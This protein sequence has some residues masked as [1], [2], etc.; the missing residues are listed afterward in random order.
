VLGRICRKDIVPEGSLSTI[1]SLKI[2][3]LDHEHRITFKIIVRKY[4]KVGVNR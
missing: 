2:S 3:P 1:L 4:L